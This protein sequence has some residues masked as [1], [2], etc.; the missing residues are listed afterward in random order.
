M[1]NIKEK[2]SEAWALPALKGCGDKE[3]PPGQTDREGADNM[4]EKAMGAMCHEWIKQ[5]E[6]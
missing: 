1:V 6:G 3:K 5:D 4:A 2:K